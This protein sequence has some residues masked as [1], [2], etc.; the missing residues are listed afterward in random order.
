VR[1]TIASLLRSTAGAAA[2]EFA[3]AAPV[4]VAALF[5]MIDLGVGLHMQMQVQQAADAGA[6]Y[7]L[8]NGFN[9]SS[10]QS[11]VTGSTSLSSLAATPAPTKTYLCQDGTTLTSSTA[12]A[13]CAN[14]AKAGTYI[15]V[16]AQASY[17]P[18]FTGMALG[19]SYTMTAQAVVRME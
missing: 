16:S 17:T 11:A 4:L 3:V 15:T 2:V 1:R 9:A 14:G 6:Q 7:A 13:T 10:I 18:I 8:I 12:G 19:S 5:P